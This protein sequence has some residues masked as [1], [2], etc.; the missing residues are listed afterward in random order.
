MSTKAGSSDCDSWSV[1][2]ITSNYHQW[3]DDSHVAHPS[4]FSPQ[5]TVRRPNTLVKVVCTVEYTVQDQKIY[6]SSLQVLR[7]V[8][9]FFRIWYPHLKREKQ[10]MLPGH[11]NFSLEIC[12]SDFCSEW[13]MKS[14]SRQRIRSNLIEFEYLVRVMLLYNT[15]NTRQNHQIL[16]TSFHKNLHI[17]GWCKKGTIYNQSLLFIRAV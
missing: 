13:V 12:F 14:S 8:E 5:I 6:V 1:K 3:R 16:L 17:I 10:E 4:D 11:F 15:Q 2:S 9:L 7:F